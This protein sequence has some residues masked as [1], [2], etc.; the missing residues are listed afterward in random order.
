DAHPGKRALLSEPLADAAQDRHVALGPV[1][2]PPAMRGERRI[3]HVVI[4]RCFLPSLT[5][6][7]GPQTTGRRRY[8]CVLEAGWSSAAFGPSSVVHGLSSTKRPGGNREAVARLSPAPNPANA[9][10]CGAPSPF[11]SVQ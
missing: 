4:H 6:D 1:D 5:M 8:R 9:G 10:R 2:P 11:P 3:F 7:D